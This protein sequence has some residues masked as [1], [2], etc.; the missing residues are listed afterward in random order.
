MVI[1]GNMWNIHMYLNNDHDCSRRLCSSLMSSSLWICIHPVNIC[2]LERHNRST[3]PVI[4]TRFWPTSFICAVKSHQ[5]RDG[6]L[7]WLTMRHLITSCL[8]LAFNCLKDKVPLRLSRQLTQGMCWP[9][10]KIQGKTFLFREAFH[11]W[12]Y[13]WL[14]VPRKP[15]FLK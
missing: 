5:K 7:C 4:F 8:S 11:A 1:Y 12:P 10:V 14:P 13:H 2:T 15:P 3:V 6:E 9:H